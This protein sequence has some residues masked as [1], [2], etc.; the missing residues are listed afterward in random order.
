VKNTLMDLNDHLFA[1]I[2]RLGQEGAA[3]DVIEA[4]IARSKAMAGLADR[5][6]ANAALVLEARQAAH[7]MGAGNMGNKSSTKM[8]CLESDNA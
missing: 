8:L 1:Q 5:V 2:E 4:E 6:I 7:E 3:P